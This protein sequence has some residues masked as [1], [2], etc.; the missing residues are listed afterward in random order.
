MAMMTL[1]QMTDTQI[2]DEADRRE[3]AGEQKHAAK[4][5]AYLRCRARFGRDPLAW[6]PSEVQREGLHYSREGLEKA[7][8]QT[9]FKAE[10]AA[11]ADFARRGVT[12]SDDEI[13]EAALHDPAVQRLLNDPLAAEF[14]GKDAIRKTIEDARP[15]TA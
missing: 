11:R 8:N 2:T 1:E 4:L 10:D 14:I 9:I 6:P 15:P 3:R 12:A 13:A 7:I 5:R